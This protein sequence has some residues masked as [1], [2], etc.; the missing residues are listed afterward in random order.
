MK[1]LHRLRRRPAQAGLTLIELMVSLVVGMIL[2]I[3]VLA[4]LA[5]SEGRKRTTNSTNDASMSGLY[6]M[7]VIDRAVRSAGG[8]FSAIQSDAHGC[9]LKVARSSTSSSG[10]TSST[11]VLPATSALPAPFGSVNPGATGTTR[12]FRLAPVL[13][14]P[15]QSTATISGQGSDVLLVMTGSG[16]RGDAPL[17]TTAVPTDTSLPV[18]NAFGVRPGDMLLVI[19]KKIAG[20]PCL[21]QQAGPAYTAGAMPIALNGATYSSATIDSVALTS[22]P[23]SSW[24][25]N[26]GPQPQFT[27]LGVGDNNTLFGYDLLQ[28]SGDNQAYEIAD[29]IFELKALYAIG[30]DTNGDGKFETTEWVSPNNTDYNLAA[31]NADPSLMG[32]I[33]AIRV[34]LIL[35]TSLPEKDPVTTGPLTLFSDAA[36]AAGTA[37]TYT[38]TLTNAEK[39]YRYRTVEMTIPVRNNL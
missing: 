1:R 28:L 3:A 7:S 16:V 27:L 30:T 18:L 22:Y 15:S 5:Q 17:P 21:V 8:G 35:R 20:Q 26:L 31:M 29:G 13:I 9:S 32:R 4:V 33:A 36:N 24:V 25:V 6:A 19:N 14:L 23:Q 39:I 12:H 37:L 38:R 2:S 11:Q 10:A 34:G